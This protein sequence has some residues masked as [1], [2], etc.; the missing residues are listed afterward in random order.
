VSEQ[1]PLLTRD[2]LTEIAHRNLRL[3][4]TAPTVQQQQGHAA[5][6]RQATY[7]LT[8]V[9]EVAAATTAV[10]FPHPAVHR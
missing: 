2:E 9:P 3:A 4:D 5:V 6:S 8:T 1:H 10:P 7:L